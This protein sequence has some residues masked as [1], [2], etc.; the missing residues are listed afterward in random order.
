MRSKVSRQVDFANQR[1]GRLVAL[2]K[3]GKNERGQS[4][5]LCKCDCGNMVT[6]TASNLK[7]Y[8]KKN[9]GCGCQMGKNIKHGLI[10]TRLYNIWAKIKERCSNP[11]NKDFPRYGGRGIFICEEWQEFKVFYDW[12]MENGYDDSLQIDRKNNDGPYSPDN[13]RWVTVKTNSNNKRNNHFITYNG[14]TK[15]IAQWGELLGIKHQ[16]L[17]SRIVTRGWDVERAF[18]TPIFK[19]GRHYARSSH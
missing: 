8:G 2:K 10:H 1:F 19:R 7:P 17:R 18:T 12:A 13:C 4:R 5:W 11:Y 14:E 16:T 6:V 15:T 3:V 9:F